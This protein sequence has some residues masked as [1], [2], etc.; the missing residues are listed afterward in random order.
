MP[1]WLKPAGSTP[2]KFGVWL[3]APPL[4]LARKV[5]GGR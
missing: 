1:R 4:T 5:G 3:A 2:T